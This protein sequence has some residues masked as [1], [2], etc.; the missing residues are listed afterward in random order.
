MVFIQNYF[1]CYLITYIFIVRGFLCN[2][3]TF[4]VYQTRHSHLSNFMRYS[5]KPAVSHRVHFEKVL[6]V[7]KQLS[8]IDYISARLK[9]QVE[10]SLCIFPITLQ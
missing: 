3:I 9:V 4:L 6:L 7:T 5:F 10:I 8:P 2:G 1:P